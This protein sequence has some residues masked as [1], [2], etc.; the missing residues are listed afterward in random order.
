MG[1]DILPPP[2]SG[3]DAASRRAQTPFAPPDGDEPS[4]GRRAL[5]PALIGIVAE[6]LVGMAI[7]IVIVIV[8][9]FLAQQA[10]GS[11]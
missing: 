8:L 4:Q 2:L 11:H 6:F 1:K 10:L 9:A 5:G 3:E 7:P